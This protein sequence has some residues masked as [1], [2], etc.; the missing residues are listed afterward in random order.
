MYMYKIFIID[1]NDVICQPKVEELKEL[2]RPLLEK[3]CLEIYPIVKN[4][5]HPRLNTIFTEYGFMVSENKVDDV[6]KTVCGKNVR[7]VYFADLGNVTNQQAF[8]FITHINLYRFKMHPHTFASCKNIYKKADI[9]V[10]KYMLLVLLVAK[11]NTEE[12]YFPERVFVNMTIGKGVRW[13]YI[14]DT[15]IYGI[16]KDIKEM[17]ELLQSNDISY[18]GFEKPIPNSMKGFEFLFTLNERKYRKLLKTK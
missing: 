8:N 12:F 1:K 16:K 5:E 7:I 18:S 2:F 13:T 14:T 11:T 4:N 10:N 17:S 15:I 3:N 9:S 6:Q